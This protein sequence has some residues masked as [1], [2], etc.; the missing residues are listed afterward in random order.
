VSSIGKVDMSFSQSMT[1]WAPFRDG[2]A[3]F[4][5]GELTAARFG[6]LNEKGVE[7]IPAVFR[8][9]N[10][11]SEGLSGVK[12]GNL[13][14][15]FIHPVSLRSRHI[16]RE[17]A[18]ARNQSRTHAPGIS[19]T[20][21]LGKAHGFI[22]TAGQV[23]IEAKFDKANSFREGRALIEKQRQCGFIDRTGSIVIEPQFTFARDFSEGLARVTEKESQPGFSPP[24]G[25]IDPDGNMLIAVKFR[26][27]NSFENGL[28]LVETEDSI[29]YINNM[30]EFAWQGPY[31][32]YGV[33][34]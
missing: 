13:W 32:E 31:V 26:C 3:P 25:F 30:G 12:V 5:I 9:A 19:S 27:G 18:R 11:F 34:I 20:V 22:D 6:Y 17:P 2:L 16:S 15:T 24:S 8:G 23:V 1:T 14:A 21:W 33:V 10:T 28:C 7:V 4:R 29:G